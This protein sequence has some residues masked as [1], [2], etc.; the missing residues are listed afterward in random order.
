MD[1]SRLPVNAANAHSDITSNTPWL[2]SAPPNLGQTT[3]SRDNC[4]GALPPYIFTSSCL[5]PCSLQ[6]SPQYTSL[7][8]LSLNPTRTVRLLLWDTWIQKWQEWYQREFCHSASSWF[9]P[10]SV[11]RK[12]KPTAVQT[13]GPYAFHQ[14]YVHL[15]VCLWASV[16]THVH[17]CVP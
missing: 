12:P 13:S 8:C 2:H 9:S 7:H 16:Y 15:Y 4:G 17:M 11:H 1:M 14:V 5:A 10:T 6:P 3:T